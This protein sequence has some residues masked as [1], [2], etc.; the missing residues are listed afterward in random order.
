MTTKLEVENVANFH[1]DHTEETLVFALEFL[2]VKDLNGDDG[3]VFDG[4][5]GG[6]G[7]REQSQQNETGRV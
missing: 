1:I 4:A 6:G 7:Q 2:L 5:V 3:R